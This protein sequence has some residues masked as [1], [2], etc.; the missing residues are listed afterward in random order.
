MLR[1]CLANLL[2]TVVLSFRVSVCVVC[3]S[4]ASNRR[5]RAGTPASP[6][7]RKAPGFVCSLTYGIF[8]IVLLH[9]GE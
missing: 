2:R 8:G 7:A 6:Q 5:R 1:E 3:A 4:T 9:N